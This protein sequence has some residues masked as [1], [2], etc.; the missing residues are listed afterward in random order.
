[1]ALF[2]VVGA[3]A[4]AQ[5][6]GEAGGNSGLGGAGGFT[7]AVLGVTPGQVLRIITGGAGAWGTGGYGGGGCGNSTCVA[8]GGRS[9]VRL[10]GGY[11]QGGDPN[12]GGDKTLIVKWS[13]PD[14][15]CPK[16]MKDMPP[17]DYVEG[18]DVV[19]RNLLQG[20]AAP[21]HLRELAIRPHLQWYR[22]A[23]HY[24][25]FRRG[26][27]GIGTPYWFMDYRHDHKGERYD[28]GGFRLQV[29]N[30]AT[31]V[32]KED[33]MGGYVPGQSKTMGIRYAQI[34]ANWWRLGAIIG[35]ILYKGGQMTDFSQSD[36]DE[37]RFALDEIWPCGDY[38]FHKSVCKTPRS[39]EQVK[40]AMRRVLDRIGTIVDRCNKGSHAM[41]RLDTL[42]R[43]I[44]LAEME[45]LGDGLVVQW[46]DL[47]VRWSK[48]P[49][50]APR[51]PW[52]APPRGGRPA[53]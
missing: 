38:D 52:G 3:E 53:G 9:A 50:A 33:G 21:L 37:L 29:P 44:K 17:K 34:S 22:D 23:T 48:D 24:Q 45:T 36:R 51:T 11:G 49:Y 26:L 1:M 6:D 47:A 14:N 31:G 16:E 35:N 19:E 2:A 10:D 46:P 27:R 13:C 40:T 43:A 32:K 28:H 5:E 18:V 39:A 20:S 7:S 42:I 30:M 4:R 12:W 15:C 25:A 8:G 41:C